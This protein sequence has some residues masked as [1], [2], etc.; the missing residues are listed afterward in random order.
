MKIIIDETLMYMEDDANYI[1]TILRNSL[2]EDTHLWNST[3]VIVRPYV[4]VPDHKLGLARR[5]SNQ[6][7]HI[8]VNV[9]VLGFEESISTLAH[10]LRHVYQRTKFGHSIAIDKVAA[11]V[12]YDAYYNHPM[13]KDARAFQQWYMR[14]AF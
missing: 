11:S 5:I 2:E 12:N 1:A 3:Q 6:C 4:N 7:Y 9:N 14:H 8:Y 13:E 10:E